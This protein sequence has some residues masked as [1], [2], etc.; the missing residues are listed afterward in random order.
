MRKGLRG[1]WTSLKA[2]IL[3]F[4]STRASRHGDYDRAL[5]LSY[6]ARR[7]GRMPVRGPRTNRKQ[8]EEHAAWLNRFK[9]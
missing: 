5:I 1:L 2:K 3:V 6:R 9:S 8:R 4:R 7:L